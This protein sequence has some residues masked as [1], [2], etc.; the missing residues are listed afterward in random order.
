MLLMSHSDFLGHCGFCKMESQIM[1]TVL[2][3]LLAW[4]ADIVMANLS[5]KQFELHPQ[6]YILIGLK[7]SFLII[8]V[9]SVLWA[10]REVEVSNNPK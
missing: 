10:R 2:C 4:V 1:T 7:F 8:T 6:K 3:L 5:P 9:T